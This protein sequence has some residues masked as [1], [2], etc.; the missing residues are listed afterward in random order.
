M[1]LLENIKYIF[2]MLYMTSVLSY[3]TGSIKNRGE[4]DNLNFKIKK[5]YESKNTIKKVKRQFAELGKKHLQI[6][7]LVSV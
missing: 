6:I 4:I 1:K 7:Y 2:M 5:L 3:N